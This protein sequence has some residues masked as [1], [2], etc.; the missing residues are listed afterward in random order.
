MT[1]GS[2]PNEILNGRPAEVNVLTSSMS[3]VGGAYNRAL[4][5]EK[6]SPPFHVGVCVCVWGGGGGRRWQWLQMTSALSLCVRALYKLFSD[7]INSVVSVVSIC[8]CSRN[9]VFIFICTRL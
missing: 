2:Y 8:K 1:L 4:K 6:S 7:F 3:P 9:S 5:T